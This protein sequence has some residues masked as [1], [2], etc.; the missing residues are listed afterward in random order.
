MLK[1]ER[2]K[3]REERNG[4]NVLEE[5]SSPRGGSSVDRWRGEGARARMSA[6]NYCIFAVW[7]TRLCVQSCHVRKWPP[8]GR[9]ER[10]GKNQRTA[11]ITGSGYETKLSRFP[12]ATTSWPNG[13]ISVLS[14]GRLQAIFDRPPILRGLLLR[15]L[16]G[17]WEF[18]VFRNSFSLFVHVSLTYVIV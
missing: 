7:C 5:G 14:L 3:E 11:S 4:K 18:C 8:R 16:V 15:F 2:L 10:G 1:N 9:E 12:S 6:K 13:T 17:K